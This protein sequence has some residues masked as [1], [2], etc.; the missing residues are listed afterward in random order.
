M[1]KT[2]I[3][4]VNETPREAVMR[5][6]G[7]IGPRVDGDYFAQE[8]ASLDRGDFDMIHIRMNSPGGNV[9]QGMSIVSAILS[10]NTPVCVHI[11]GIAAS[12]AA[13]V[14]VAAD[15]VCMMDFAKMMIHDPYF[16]GESGKATSPKQKK[17][18]AR[19]TDMLRQVLVRRGK[20]EA[21]MAKLMREETWFSA[22]EAL[23]AGLCDEITSSARNEFM[24]LDPMQLV[25]AVDAEYQ[26]NNQEQME[27]INLSAEAIVALGSKAARWTKLPSAQRSSRPSRPKTRRSPTSRPRR[28]RPKRKSPG[29]GRRRRTPWPPRR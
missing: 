6:Y 24:N 22:A 17:A 23:D 13:V 16:T 3:D 21:T 14:A 20:D 19:L 18:L 25:A 7:A 1:E 8:L 11:D 9:F 28:R 29:S 27:K 10:M 5:L 26:T 15:R 12:M 2:Y 4:S